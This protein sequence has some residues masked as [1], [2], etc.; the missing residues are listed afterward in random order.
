MERHNFEDCC[1]AL[2]EGEEI[3]IEHLGHQQSG[4]ILFCRGGMFEVRVGDKRESWPPEACEE[5]ARSSESPH[6]NL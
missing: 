3:V 4:K 5:V 1:Q 2:A 6:R